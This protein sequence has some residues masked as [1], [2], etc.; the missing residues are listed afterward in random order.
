[1]SRLGSMIDGLRRT[2]QRRMRARPRPSRQRR[3]PTLFSGPPPRYAGPALIGKAITA[4]EQPSG[5]DWIGK[6]V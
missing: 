6:A 1:M 5:P 4:P 2:V 3:Y